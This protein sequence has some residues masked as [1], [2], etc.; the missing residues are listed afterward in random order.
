MQADRYTRLVNW[1]KVLLPLTALALL[2][3]LFLLS[4]AI[5]PETA[6]PF[7]DK[8]IQDRLRDQVV[9]GP[10]YYGTTAEGDEIAFSAD[11]LTTP[12]GEI[13]ANTAQKVDVV[14]DLASGSQIKLSADIGE[15]DVGQDTA[16]LLGNVN[17]NT[18]TGYEITSA[19]MIALMSRLDVRSPGPVQSVG[20]VGTLNAGS[21]VLNAP[22]KDGPTQLVFTNGVKLIYIPKQDKE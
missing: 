22:I 18:S 14:M 12:Q 6:I 3:T 2:S 17:I 5:D 7:A 19:R 10:F 15:F 1:L 20:P 4:R 13:G 16:D 11:T 8:E 21:M 9:T